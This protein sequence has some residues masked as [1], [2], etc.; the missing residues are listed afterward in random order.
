M[1][2]IDLLLPVVLMLAGIVVLVKGGGWTVDGSVFV[3]RRFGI[4]PLVVGF[5]IIAFGTSLPELVISV[6]ANLEGSP[7]I[8]LGNVLG[9]NIANVLLVIGATAAMVPLVSTSRAVLK[10]LLMM[11]VSTALLAFLL[12]Y[13]DIY[14]MAG[15]GMVLLLLIYIYVQYK[16]AQKSEK[17]MMQDVDEVPEF[18]KPA[19][20]YLFLFL[21]LVC[22]AFGAE[23]LVTGARQTAS[24]IGV[25]E[26]VVALS[27]VALGTSLPELSTCI[28]AARKGH[29]QIA[30]GNIV[31][32]NVFNILMIMGTTALIK[33]IAAGSFAPQLVNLDIWVVIFSSAI[34]AMLIVLFDKISRPVGFVFCAAYLVY[35]IY[36]Y[37]LY[38]AP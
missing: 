14:R 5:T 8:A 28:I 21:G 32:S 22:V 12:S 18:S 6:L 38:I 15:L 17:P 19:F 37:A 20:A 29:A 34:F 30:I 7:D 36:I 16:S 31:G 13:G 2:F 9:S 27:I 11:L 25:P 33:P 10:D 26:A 23:I 35:N 24:L 1:D 4:S 3:A